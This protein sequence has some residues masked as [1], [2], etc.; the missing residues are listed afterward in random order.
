VELPLALALPGGAVP[1]AAEPLIPPFLEAHPPIQAD[2]PA[3]L[4]N[5][6]LTANQERSLELWLGRLNTL[7]HLARLRLAQ[8]F[9]G[10]DMADIDAA[11]DLLYND[12][13]WSTTQLSRFITDLIIQRPRRIRQL[14]VFFITYM[15]NPLGFEQ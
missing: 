14:T 5:G 12:E 8:Q 6:P 1:P 10:V 13:R 7:K 2:A 9:P 4:N 15:N 3:P 11:V